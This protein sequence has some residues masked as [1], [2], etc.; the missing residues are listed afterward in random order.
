MRRADVTAAH[1]KAWMRKH[2]PRTQD[3]T[4]MMVCWYVEWGGMIIG[5]THGWYAAIAVKLKPGDTRIHAQAKYELQFVPVKLP[6]G[7]DG[8]GWELRGE[9]LFVCQLPDIG[10][11]AVV[12]I[13]S[14]VMKLW[15]DKGVDP[16]RADILADFVGR[17]LKRCGDRVMAFVDPAGGHSI[18]A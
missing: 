18:E 11:S 14:A 4:Q 6:A 1:G 5:N 17:L 2:P 15:I 10:D 8:P 7:V 3:Q 12:G 13:V 9:P 16:Q